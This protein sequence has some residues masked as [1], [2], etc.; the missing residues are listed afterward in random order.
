MDASR[1]LCPVPGSV[2]SSLRPP[3]RGGLAWLLAAS[4]R[5]GD[6]CLGEG[7]QLVELLAELAFARRA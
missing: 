6:L 5:P 2:R 4:A 3:G 7:L 1:A